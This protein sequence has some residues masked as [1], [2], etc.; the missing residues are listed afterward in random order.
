MP[1][2]DDTVPAD[3]VERVMALLDVCGWPDEGAVHAVISSVLR[4]PFD[5]LMEAMG[6]EHVGAWRGRPTY[7]T[8]SPDEVLSALTDGMLGINDAHPFE[9]R[10]DG[11]CRCGRERD[12]VLHDIYDATTTP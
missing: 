2:T 3:P 8:P 4:V 11:R 5:Q 1:P 9:A 10:A 6:A 12:A 7:V